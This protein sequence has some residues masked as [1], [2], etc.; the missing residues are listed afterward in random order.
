MRSPALAACAAAVVLALGGDAA[1]DNGVAWLSADIRSADGRAEIRL[2]LQWL[3]STRNAEHPTL[4]VGGVRIDCVGLWN[5]YG[6]LPAGEI[7]EIE[8]GTSESGETY[9]I[10][11]VSD[12]PAPAPAEGKVRILNRDEN[13]KNTEVGFPLSFA[14]FLDGIAEF[15]PQWMDDDDIGELESQ[16]FSLSGSVELVKLGDYGPF[17]ALDARDAKSRVRIQIE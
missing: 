14:K 10:R 1:A 4:S 13:G 5:K 9:L 12:K 3:A 16:G 2:P 7:R 6:T 8:K 15:V 17:T 11:V